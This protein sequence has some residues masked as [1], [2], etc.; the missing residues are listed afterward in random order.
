MAPT[1]L[2]AILIV[3]FCLCL[4]C[5]VASNTRKSEMCGG[6]TEGEVELRQ[7]KLPELVQR[8][9]SLLF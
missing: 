5:L 8:S 2:S 6:L 7:V 1:L 4:S 9:P 3:L